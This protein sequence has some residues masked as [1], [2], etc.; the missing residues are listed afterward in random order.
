MPLIQNS[1]HLK[2]DNASGLSKR[3]I[4]PKSEVTDNPDT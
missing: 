1:L 4:V 3:K 2:H